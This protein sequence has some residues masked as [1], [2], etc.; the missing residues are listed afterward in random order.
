MDIYVIPASEVT[1][2]DDRTS[3]LYSC[4]NMKAF[5]DDYLRCIVGDRKLKGVWNSDFEELKELYQAETILLFE[6]S[7]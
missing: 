6:V 4:K 1:G 3:K 2:T 5:M 7:R